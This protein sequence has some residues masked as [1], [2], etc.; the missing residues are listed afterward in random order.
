MKNRLP[1]KYAAKQSC[2]WRGLV[3]VYEVYFDPS[4]RPEIM[5]VVETINNGKAQPY[6]NPHSTVVPNWLMPYLTPEHMRFLRE[7]GLQV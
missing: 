1:R 6:F 3:E 4:R 7:F 2:E 5:D